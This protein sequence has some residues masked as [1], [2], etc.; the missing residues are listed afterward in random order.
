MDANDQ[1]PES[2]SPSQ[3]ALVAASGAG[4]VSFLL[5][6]GIADRWMTSIAAGALEWAVCATFAVVVMFA[7][8]YS[9]GWHREITGA[10]RLAAVLALSCSIFAVELVAA[11]IIACITAFFVVP[12]VFCLMTLLGNG[13]Y[14]P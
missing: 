2:L 4:L 5:I 12:A 10:A 11:A 7:V 8:L 3:R 1:M 14:H 6:Y 13:G 9:S